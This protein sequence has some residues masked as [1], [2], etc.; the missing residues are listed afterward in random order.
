[1]S[2]GLDVSTPLPFGDLIKMVHTEDTRREERQVRLGSVF[3]SH[4][5]LQFVVTSFQI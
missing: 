3:K 1:M 2:L 5:L 4:W